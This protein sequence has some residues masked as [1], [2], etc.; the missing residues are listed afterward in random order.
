MAH[1]PELYDTIVNFCN[2]VA[3]GRRAK[4]HALLEAL[5]SLPDGIDQDDIRLFHALERLLDSVEERETKLTELIAELAALRGEQESRA[6]KLTR[7]NNELRAGLHGGFKQAA[8][9]TSDPA[10]RLAFKQ[11]ARIASVP[12]P[13]LIT[14]ETG[15]GKGLIAKYIHYAGSRAKFPLVSLNCA[16]IPASLLESELFGIEKGV[17]SGVSER[18]GHFESASNGTLFLDEIGDMPLE[19]QAKILTAIE[20]KSITRLGGRKPLPVDARL[21]SATHRNLENACAKG[22]FRQDLFYRLQVIH[23]H[24]PPL[25][26]RPGDIRPLAAHFLRAAAGRYGMDDPDFAPDSLRLLESYYWPGNVRELEHEVERATLLTPGPL[27]QPGDFSRRL[28]TSYPFALTSAM[29]AV[30]TAQP[31]PAEDPA[32]N[33]TGNLAGKFQSH[34]DLLHDIMRRIAANSARAASF[35]TARTAL[36]RKIRPLSFADPAT[37]APFAGASLP[38]LLETERE[39]VRRALNDCN[40]NKTH[41]AQKLGL[42]REGLRKKLRRLGLIV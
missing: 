19:C 42:S 11:A 18:M 17:A 29:N 20:S 7:E 2:Q 24:I 40:G 28:T 31:R 3:A 26:E 9:L 5:P 12:V 30:G 1:V 36:L 8:A 14:G 22:E 21:I 4:A 25:R 16:A 13:V 38:S 10:M 6:E 32:E 15:V 27:I 35:D 39:L 33:L 41:A 34:P 37:A 23:I